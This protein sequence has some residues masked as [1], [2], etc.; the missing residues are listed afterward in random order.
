MSTESN[1]LSEARNKVDQP[2]LSAK[3]ELARNPRTGKSDYRYSIPDRATIA[4]DIEHLR[5]LNPRWSNTSIEERGERLKKFAKSIDNHFDS[6]SDALEQDTG[7]RKISQLE[8]NSVIGMIHSWISLSKQFLP[9]SWTQGIQNPAIK[10]RPQFIPYPLVGVISPWNFPLLLSFIDS[11]PALLAGCSVIIKPSEITPRFIEPLNITVR[12]S[13]LSD[14]LVIISGN[15]VTGAALVKEVDAICFTG[16]VETGRKIASATAKRMIPTFLELGGKDPLVILEGADLDLASDAA[17]RGSVLSSGQACQSIER[18][19][20]H[21]SIAD[22]LIELL[23][24]K[25]KKVRLN[26]PEISVGDIGPII[27]E[28][29]ARILQDHIKDAKVQGGKIVT[30]GSVENLGGGLWLRPTVISNVN[31]NMKVMC[32]ET[33]GPIMPVMT[34]DTNEEAIALANDTEFG[35]SAAVIA[36]T[37]EEAE[38][39]GRRINAGAISLNDAALTSLFYEAEKHSFKNSGLGGSRMG[40]AGFQRFLQRKALIANTSAPT[41]LCVFAEDST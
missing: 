8:I 11:I 10:H 3:L 40:M 34:F 35:L 16:S 27:S 21:S 7:R 28:N 37:L 15:G 6:I 12:E 20:V 36:A 30:G 39:V 26:W 29:Q 17:L 31:H 19:Y 41:S 33:F 5:R 2:I 18:I 23:V 1:K 22:K 14:H 38:Y 32:E 25:T 24:E 9:S 13:G 4:N